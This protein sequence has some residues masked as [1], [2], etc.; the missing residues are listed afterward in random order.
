MPT[1]ACFEGEARDLRGN[2][3]PAVASPFGHNRVAKL[4]SGWRLDRHRIARNN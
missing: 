4:H 2:A 3:Q 1:V